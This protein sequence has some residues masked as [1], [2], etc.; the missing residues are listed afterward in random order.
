MDECGLFIHAVFYNALVN[1]EQNRRFD[2]DHN[3][4]TSINMS[5]LTTIGNRY[6][7]HSTRLHF[8][9]KSSTFRPIVQLFTRNGDSIII[10]VLVMTD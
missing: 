3:P 5:V 4:V 6:G 1:P 9:K 8:S 2:K 7:S 10:I